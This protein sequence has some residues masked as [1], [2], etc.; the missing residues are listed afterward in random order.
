M[1]IERILPH[2]LKKLEENTR[3]LVKEF[4]SSLNANFSNYTAAMLLFR[5]LLLHLANDYNESK[6]GRTYEFRN[7]Q[8]AIDDLNDELNLNTWYYDLLTN[9]KNTVNEINHDYKVLYSGDEKIIEDTWE[10]IRWMVEEVL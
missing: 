8:E 6:Y 7:F 3:E 1:D 4:Y 2:K 5:P 9:I 10:F